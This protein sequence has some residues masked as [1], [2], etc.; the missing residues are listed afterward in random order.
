M[1]CRR[2]KR[3]PAQ[4]CRHLSGATLGWTPTVPELSK[5]GHYQPI[6][7]HSGYYFTSDASLSLITSWASR[8]ICCTIPAAGITSLTRFT[9]IPA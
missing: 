6:P 2:I 7:G 3:L 5:G 1:S 8:A 4:P 9:D